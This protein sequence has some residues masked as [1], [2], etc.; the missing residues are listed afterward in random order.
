MR[1][2]A[3]AENVRAGPPAR[4]LIVD[5][6]EVSRAAIGALLRTEGFEVTDVGTDQDPVAVAVAFSPAVAVVDVT[7]ERAAG[8]DIAGKLVALADPP[9]V[10]L[11]SSALRRR[12]GPRLDGQFFVAKADLCSAALM[13]E[14]GDG[15]FRQQA[16]WP[17]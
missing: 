15:R 10:V 14:L 13:R 4:I 12:F 2:E 9:A 11:T 6:H 17:L 3:S 5:D 8:F 1:S 16:G 7:P